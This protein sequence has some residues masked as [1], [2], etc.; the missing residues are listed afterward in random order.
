MEL[1]TPYP[2]STPSQRR[3]EDQEP[4]PAPSRGLGPDPASALGSA[5][6][7]IDI[8]APRRSVLAGGRQIRVPDGRVGARDDIRDW[9]FLRDHGDLIEVLSEPGRGSCFSVWLPL[10]GDAPV[11]PTMRR[12]SPGSSLEPAATQLR[13][14]LVMDDEPAVLEVMC[15]ML[16]LLDYR[17]IATEDGQAAVDAWNLAASGEGAPLLAIF[18]LTVR[19][20]MGGVDAAAALRCTHPDARIIASSGYVSDRALADYRQ[21][22]FDG[23]LRKPYRLQQ[24]QA[25][26]LEVLAVPSP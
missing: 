12:E 24:L 13:T 8:A 23:V 2:T 17:V 9:L 11:G 3:C 7:H 10:A 20:G 26:I 16:E 5:A 21:H 4:P 19:G 18:D 6:D 1:Q 22:G 14:V 15:E 25:A